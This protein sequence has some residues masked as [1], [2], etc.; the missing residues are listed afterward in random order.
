MTKWE[1]FEQSAEFSRLTACLPKSL[2]SNVVTWGG[3]MAPVVLMDDVLWLSM[4]VEQEKQMQ[5]MF[6]QWLVNP[7]TSNWYHQLNWHI[8]STSDSDFK[9]AKRLSEGILAQQSL[10][11]AQLRANLQDVTRH[12]YRVRPETLL[13]ADYLTFPWGELGGEKNNHF[14]PQNPQ[15]VYAMYRIRLVYAQSMLEEAD[16]SMDI[17][18]WE[19]FIRRIELGHGIFTNLIGSEKPS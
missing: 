4:E 15:Q 14:I 10:K 8:S 7:S 12:S 17:L 3:M 5:A 11:V 1:R 19:E 16:D 9:K 18:A 6:E 13:I 2:V